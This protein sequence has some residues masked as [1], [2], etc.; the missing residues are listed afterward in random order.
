MNDLGLNLPRLTIHY[1]KFCLKFVKSET[2][3]D[4][5][6]NITALMSVACR[7]KQSTP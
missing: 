4:F 1:S 6:L 3:A 2:K 7:A 5:Q